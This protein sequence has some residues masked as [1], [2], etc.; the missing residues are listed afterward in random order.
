MSLNPLCSFPK[1]TNTVKQLLMNEAHDFQEFLS[2][3]LQQ[4]KGALT[5]TIDL[6]TDSAMLRS[7][8]GIT[9]HFIK[10]SKVA[11]RCVGLEE[12][13][14]AH[15]HENVKNSVK[16]KLA[17][18]GLTLSDIVAIITDNGSNVVKAFN[19]YQGNF[20]Y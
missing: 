1:S 20:Y 11:F 5:A 10:S 16:K 3:E 14:G 7:Y 12:I 4:F 2:T 15:S 13:I 9:L 17:M 19:E 6:W 18:F 8:V